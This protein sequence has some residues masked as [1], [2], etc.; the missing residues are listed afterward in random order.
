MQSGGQ[1]GVDHLQ[2]LVQRRQRQR[3]QLAFD[4][5][6]KLPIGRRPLKHAPQQRLEIERRPADE[7]NLPAA[8][9]DIRNRRMGR[10]DILAQAEFLRWATPNPADGVA[11]VPARPLPRLRGANIHVPI[12]RH[13]IERDDFR[14]E[15]QGQLHANLGLP[16]S[17]RPGQIPAIQRAEAGGCV[18][19][20]KLSHEKSSAIV[21]I[22][23][24]LTADL[25]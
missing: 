9:L 24:R 8:I 1:Q 12:E 16:R 2:A 5:G 22:G 19:Q 4:I 10:V 14:I 6:P 17:R 20:G 11:H 13:R 21:G 25:R 23:S 15:A 3:L 18:C 7:Q